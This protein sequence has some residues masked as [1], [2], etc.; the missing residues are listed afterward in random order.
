M[1]TVVEESTNGFKTVSTVSV[2]ASPIR[3]YDAWADVSRWW[4]SSHSFSLDAKN[5]SIDLT[6]GGQFLESIGNGQGVVHSTVIFA[7]R[8]EL[9]RLSGALGPLQM[10]GAHGTLSIEFKGNRQ[11][12]ELVATYVVIGMD[13]H[14]W[15]AAVEQVLHEQLIRLRNYVET[16]DAEMELPATS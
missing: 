13:L 7:K 4:D 14:G 6:V 8:G 1:G 9:L 5:L 16:G 12:T 15:A 2:H 10:L 11:D 3:V